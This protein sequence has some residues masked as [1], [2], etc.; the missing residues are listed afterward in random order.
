MNKTEKKLLNIMSDLDSNDQNNVLSFAEFLLDKA[1]QD[2]RLTIVEEPLDIPRPKEE[3]VVAAIKRLSETYPMIKK[4]IMLD[5][6]A[7]LMSAH[8]LQGR[9]AVDVID[10]LQVLFEKRYEEFCQQHENT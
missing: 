4:N 7:S 2:G 10:E 5:E 9:V 6:T 8:I 1:K 3:R